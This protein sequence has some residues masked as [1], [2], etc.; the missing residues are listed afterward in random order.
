M[1]NNTGNTKNK[2]ENQERKFKKINEK[3]GKPEKQ[4]KTRKEEG[5]GRLMFQKEIHSEQQKRWEPK[6][7]KEKEEESR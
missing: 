5:A 1:E 4:R 7:Q 6:Q 3:L 2:R